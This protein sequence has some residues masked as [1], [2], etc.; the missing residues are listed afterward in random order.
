MFK[1]LLVPVDQSALAEQAL[2][3]AASIARGSRAPMDLAMVLAPRDATAAAHSDAAMDNAAKYLGVIAAELKNGAGV[4]AT[5]GVLRGDPAEMICARADDVGADLVVM[6]THGRTGLSKAWLG[7]VAEGVVRRSPVPVLVVRAREKPYGAR[8]AAWPPMK[9]VVVTV[10]GSALSAEILPSAINLAKIGNVSVVLLQVVQPVPEMV[11]DASM[12]MVT[13]LPI[14]DDA[15]TASVMKDAEENLASLVRQ[16]RDKGVSNSE[17]HAILGTNVAA[18]IAEFAHGHHADV[19]AM[20]T[21][22]RGMSKLV[23]GSV[24]DKVR[25]ASDIPVLL[26]RPGSVERR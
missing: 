17:S 24:A 19:I 10:D 25:R 15:A 4:T 11:F 13:A 8:S 21:H 18:T 22:G 6:T 14:T 7:S 16:L 9:Q 23:V 20:S 5:H 1:K 2:G 12:P 26:R 3:L